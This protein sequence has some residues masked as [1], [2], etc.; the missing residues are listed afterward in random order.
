MLIKSR[1][2]LLFKKQFPEP[3][4]FSTPDTSKTL[5]SAASVCTLVLISR[6]ACAPESNKSTGEFL[7]RLMFDGFLLNLDLF[8]NVFKDFQKMNLNSELTFLL[9]DVKVAVKPELSGITIETA[10]DKVFRR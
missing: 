8:A 4:T 2:L 7:N 10:P 1:L 9:Y 3:L 5:R 6:R